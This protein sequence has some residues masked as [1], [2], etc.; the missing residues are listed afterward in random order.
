MFLGHPG[1]VLPHDGKDRGRLVM[2]RAAVLEV[3]QAIGGGSRA[4][5]RHWHS[6]VRQP[7]AGAVGLLPVGVGGR[8]PDCGLTRQSAR[9]TPKETVRT[10]AIARHTLVREI[11]ERLRAFTRDCGKK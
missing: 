11:Y 6:Y 2:N 1:E 7:H 3:L 9:E 10:L 4:S 5:T 8:D